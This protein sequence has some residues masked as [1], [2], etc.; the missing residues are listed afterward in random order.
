MKAQVGV[1]EVRFF[2]AQ[3][4][5]CLEQNVIDHKPPLFMRQ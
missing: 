2:N 3:Q 1:S 5:I 4:K